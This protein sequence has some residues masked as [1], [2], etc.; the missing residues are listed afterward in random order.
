MKQFFRMLSSAAFVL[1]LQGAAFSQISITAGDLPNYFGAGNS[2]FSY[3]STDTVTMDIGTA[4]NSAPETWSMPSVTFID[5]TRTDNVLPASTPYSSDF[6]GATYAQTQS[7]SEGTAT[8]EYYGYYTLSSNTLWFVGSVEHEAGSV[9]GHAVDTSI[10]T[11]KVQAVFTLPVQLGGTMTSGPDTIYASGNDVEVNTGSTKY[12][13]Y[14]S[15]TLPNGTFPALRVNGTTITKIYL[16][17]SLINTLPSYTISWLTGSGNQ[18]SVEVDSNASGSV[19]V[20]SVSLTTVGP[21]PATLVKSPAKL[22][23][24]FVLSQNYP[25]PFNPSTQIQ[26]SVPKAG[27]VTLKVYDMLGR[28]VATLVNGELSASSYSITWNAANVASGMYLYKLEAGKYSVTKK[29]VLMK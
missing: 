9:S 25:N 15:L 28:E 2:W 23:G 29:M 7:F 3:R 19:K 6:P 14:G 5:T 16:S 27:F 8:S 13:A 22:P 20:R 12:D 17:G 18:L 21:T 10:I 26:F 4:S 1:F 24:N 11:H